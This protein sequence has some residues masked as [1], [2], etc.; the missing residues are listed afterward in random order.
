M[1]APS[2][3]QQLS[4]RSTFIFKGT[5]LKLK[6]ATIPTVPVNDKTAV[7][8][9]DQVLR[10]PAALAAYAGHDITVQLTTNE[11]V[12]RGEQ[13]IFYTNGWL[14][15]NGI[16]VQSV[17][18]TDA[19]RAASERSVSV[20]DA[21]Q[22][23]ARRML[24]DHVADVDLI[25]RGRVGSVRLPAES[26]RRTSRSPRGGAPPDPISEH[27]GRW[28]EAVVDVEEISKSYGE[29]PYKQVVVRF[30]SST[31]VRWANVPKFQPGQEGVF[32]LHDVGMTAG[33]G[34]AKGSTAARKKPG[35]Q[36]YT[37]LHPQDFQPLQKGQEIRALVEAAVGKKR[38]TAKKT[39]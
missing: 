21:I 6:D 16:A 34:T 35:T 37:A 2:S 11:T 20:S 12:K 5:V 28:R 10:A 8:H 14:F 26:S 32:L 23:K 30:P 29:R 1:S 24:E 39:R 7:V 4:K 38:P 22:A 9:V 15:G 3:P 18:H 31:D 33:A 25:V 17:G 13:A 36:C 27:A 19:T